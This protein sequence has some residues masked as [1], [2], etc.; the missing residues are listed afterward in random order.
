MLEDKMSMHRAKMLG[1]ASATILLAVY[2]P[3]YTYLKAG[4]RG[5]FNFF[6]GD[7]FLYLS[8]ARYSQHGFFTFDGERMTNGFHP[9]WQ[10]ILTFLIQTLDLANQETQLL[11]TFFL[12]TALTAIGLVFANL[13]ILR[14]TN[15]ALLSLLTIPGVYF[16]LIGSI[17]RNQHVWENICG[18]ESALS[19]FFGGLILYVFA[20]AQ[21]DQSTTSTPSSSGVLCRLFL[22]FGLVFP[23]IVLAR[24]DDIFLVVSFG[25]IALFLPLSVRDRL[26]A[27]I[28]VGAPTAVVLFVYLIF[29][30]LTMG[31]W[32]PI[33]G[34]VKSN[35]F[36]FASSIYVFSTNLFPPILDLKN[37]IAGRQSDGF[38][39][40]Q[41]IFRA[42]QML[43]P[44]FVSGAFLF[45]ARTYY[46]TS[47]LYRI[48]SG[49][50]LYVIMK[51]LYNF[52]NVNLWDQGTWYYALPMLL[53][54]FLTAVVL[55]DA[56][57]LASQRTGVVAVVAMFYG[58]FVLLSAGSVTSDMTYVEQSRTYAFWKNRDQTSRAIK[59]VLGEGRGLIEFGDGIVNFSLDVPCVHGFTFAGDVGSFEAK[60]RGEFLSY[61]YAR[62]F[63]I[64]TSAEYF[65]L[66]AKVS[67]SKQ[68]RDFLKASFLDDKTKGELDRF[69]YEL[70]YYEKDAG[71]PFIRF[72]PRDV[73]G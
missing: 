73:A 36:S 26:K 13:A 11:L 72:Y 37:L 66:P 64:L 55:K 7:S 58:L 10:Y 21:V 62:G 69:D 33:S 71:A 70:V 8:I 44:I 49:F 48:A 65:D 35:P 43:Y 18:M 41:N 19:I 53:V 17:Y 4:M 2:P 61:S 1:V 46:R 25:L 52:F 54:S 42:V 3:V 29:N 23:F 20:S 59:A 40:Y 67:T 34:T 32:M 63:R 14:I 22:R 45:F 50:A 5:V 68:L 56:Y 12:C 39:L 6:A 60:R 9:L 57:A 15:S 47:L 27:T 28:W 30:K 24:L 38:T 31:I 51:G 16:A